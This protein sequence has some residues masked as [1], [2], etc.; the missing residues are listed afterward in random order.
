MPLYDI[1]I[2]GVT[3]S[4][5]WVQGDIIDVKPNPFYWSRCIVGPKE[6]LFLALTLNIAEEESRKLKNPYYKDGLEPDRVILLNPVKIAAQRYSIPISTILAPGWFPTLS[7]SRVQDVND[8][9]QPFDKQ[10]IID[11]VNDRV[12]VIYD[13]FKQGYKYQARRVA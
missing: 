13:K 3:S 9:Y 12:A 1:I 2:L 11:C 5:P 10:I 6:S 7:I 8:A 4:G